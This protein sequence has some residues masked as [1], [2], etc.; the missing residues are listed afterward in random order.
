VTRLKKDEWV[1]DNVLSHAFF[2]GRSVEV[3]EE[4]AYMEWHTS[5]HSEALTTESN[6]YEGRVFRPVL[7]RHNSPA[8]SREMLWVRTGQ[9]IETLKPG[10]LI[11]MPGG[12]KAFSKRAG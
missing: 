6:A 9:L 4:G 10:S 5:H 3:R 1:D 7:A 11:G 8:I 2:C 12:A